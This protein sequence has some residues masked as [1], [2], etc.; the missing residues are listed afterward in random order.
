M[1][2]AIVANSMIDALDY[3]INKVYTRYLFGS[4]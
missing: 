4:N 3:V 1:A 2:G